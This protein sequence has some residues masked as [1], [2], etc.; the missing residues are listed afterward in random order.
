M[1]FISFIV[2]DDH[3]S[4]LIEADRLWSDPDL[5]SDSSSIL[6]FRNNIQHC[7]KC[8]GASATE[9]CPLLVIAC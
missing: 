9:Q 4:S 2:D 3:R 5:I 6:N 8:E 1:R 7:S